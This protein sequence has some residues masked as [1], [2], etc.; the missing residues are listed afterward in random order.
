MAELP[1]PATVNPEPSAAPFP[2]EI[3]RLEQIQ[4]MLAEDVSKAN[5]SLAEQDEAYTVSKR[6]MVEN[7]GELDPHDHCLYIHPHNVLEWKLIQR[8]SQMG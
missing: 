1:K 7:R 8:R 4:A 5:Q 3:I 6:Y 2:E